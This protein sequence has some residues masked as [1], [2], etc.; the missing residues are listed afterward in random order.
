MVTL[1][2]SY[3]RL[4]ELIGR[5]LSIKQIESVLF[6]IGFELDEVAGDELKIDITSDRPDCVSPQGMARAIRSYLGIKLGLIDY[7]SKFKKSNYEFIV[8]D[9]LRKIRPYAVSCIIKNLNFTDKLIRDVIWVQEKLHATYGRDRSKA[10]IGIYPFKGIVPPIHLK[11]ELPDK[12]RFVPLEFDRELT[13]AQIL[14]E[15]PTGQKYAGIIRGFNKYP[16]LTDS[17]G[18]V[19]SMPPIINSQNFGRVTPDTHE[20]FIEVTGTDWLTVNQVLTILATMFAD[21][22]GV[23][24]QMKVKYSDKTYYTPLIKPDRWSINLDYI[25]KSLGRNFSAKEVITLLGRMGIDCK[26]IKNKLEVQVPFYRT[27]VLHPIDLI[28][29]IARA[30]GFNNFEPIMPK[31]PTIGGLLPRNIFNNRVRELMVGHGLIEVFTRALTTLEDQFNKVNLPV[32]KHVSVVKPKCVESIL[33]VSLAPELMKCFESNTHGDYPQRIFEVNDITLIDESSD[34]K[35]RNETRLCAAICSSSTNFTE[36]KELLESLKSSLGLK[37]ELREHDYG[38]LIKGRSASINHNGKQVGFI[39][40]VHPLVI[41]NFGLKLPVA[42][43]ELSLED[44]Y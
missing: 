20:I 7:A 29:D 25:N 32:D 13:G 15:H 4:I 41:N 1:D 34:V 3:S 8:H 40:E 39:G 31:S 21:E 11:A 23:V 36:I 28:D 30:Y 16:V 17:A 27:D 38:M 26:L 14:K 9:S 2:V 5:R 22:G 12:I 24:Y 18:N 42:V 10:A 19:L 33:R 44:F 6:D 35:S 37:L 43:F